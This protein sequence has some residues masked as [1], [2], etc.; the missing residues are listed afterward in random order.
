MRISVVRIVA[1]VA[2]SV[3]GASVLNLTF[4]SPLLFPVVLFSIAVSLSLSRGFVRALPVVVGIG[5]TADIATLGRI[6]LLAAFSAG[7]AYVAGFISR[8]FTVE[9]GLMM[10]VFAGFLVGAG[11]LWFLAVSSWFDGSNLFPTISWGRAVPAIGMGIV[12]FTVVS[13]ILS[14]FEQWLS[15]FDSPNAF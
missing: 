6:G 8:R 5:L 9:H 2:L 4:S 7:V 12:L 13:A 14:R 1:V 15:Y 10:H 3:L 11:A